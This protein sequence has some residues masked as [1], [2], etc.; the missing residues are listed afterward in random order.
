MYT[1]SII[2]QDLYK[3]TTSYAYMKMFPQATGTFKFYDR[4]HTKYTKE[5]VAK[6]LFVGVE[7]CSSIK[8]MF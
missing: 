7:A 5:E 4:N 2:D 3:F 1:N 8:I 6:I